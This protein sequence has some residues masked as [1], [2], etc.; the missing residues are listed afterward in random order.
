M[1]HL[2]NTII[3][4]VVSDFSSSSSAEGQS[5]QIDV[6]KDQLKD[7]IEESCLWDQLPREVIIHIFRYL[8][9]SELLRVARV[10][11]CWWDLIHTTSSL[12]RDMHLELSCNSKSIH[13]K[14]ACWYASQFG[15]HFRKLSV[16]CVHDNNHMVCR[17]M[18]INFRRLLLTL[19]QPELTSLKVTDLKLRGALM[20]TVKSISEILTR[21]LSRLE[22][23]QC[24]K[25]TSSLFRIDEGVKVIDT[26]LT[27]SRGTLQSLVID[28]FFEAT[29]LAQRPAEFE[30]VTNGILS[31]NRLTKLSIDYQL[32]TDSFVT[33]LSR[34]HTGQLKVLK[35]SAFQ[36]S[37][38]DD[39]TSRS[40]WL[41]LI[42]A[43]PT[44]K[45]AFYIEGWVLSPF[46]SILDILDP[47]LP[48]YRIWL[49]LRSRFNYFDMQGSSAASVLED[50][51]TSFRQ[52][53]VKFE[54]NVDNKSDPVDAAILKLVRKCHR[55]TTVKVRSLPYPTERDQDGSNTDAGTV[56][57][58]DSSKLNALKEIATSSLQ[59]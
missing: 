36:L 41:T 7:K 57:L 31:L 50:I 43:C 24:F 3:C 23:L 21:M 55:L 30:R 35:I 8:G 33:A 17:L 13:R 19:H 56:C 27:V 54:M 37:S 6:L 32:L 45:V 12:W 26:V 46:V 4:N 59:R 39:K 28:G 52:S 34:S 48:V 11:K 58:C 40:S 25:M 22:G 47:V 44:L 20:C 9:K 10:C 51:A 15:N 53:L 14:R 1:A 29:F 42:E 38:K 49:M 16:T 2:K 5:S 18:G